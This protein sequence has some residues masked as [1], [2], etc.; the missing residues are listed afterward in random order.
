MAT[1]APV[2]AD[3]DFEHD[4]SNQT[5]IFDPAQHAWPLTIIGLGGIGSQLALKAAKLGVSGLVLYDDD[6]VERHNLPY[7]MYRPCDIGLSKAEATAEILREY[8]YANVTAHQGRVDETT[9]LSG[10]VISGVDSMASRHAIWASVQFNPEVLLYMDGRIGGEHVQLYTLNPCDPD[11]IDRYEATLFSDAEAA[12]LPCA[13]RAVIHPAMDVAMRMLTQ[14]TNFTRGRLVP[15][16]VMTFT[17]D[18]EAYAF[19]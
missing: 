14:L 3:T 2:V 6:L 19:A 9:R 11:A 4:Y 18:F 13:A 17:P 5:D 7:Q 12:P 1:A 8:G 10:V 15:F 16:N